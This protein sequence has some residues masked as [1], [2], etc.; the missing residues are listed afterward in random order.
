MPTYE[1]IDS[2]NLESP[3]PENLV[4]ERRIR[5]LKFLNTEIKAIKTPIW[6]DV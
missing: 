1:K 3:I 6:K 4:E 5:E 2:D